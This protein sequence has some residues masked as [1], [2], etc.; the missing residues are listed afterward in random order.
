[1][2]SDNVG[3]FSSI[4]YFIVDGDIEVPILP[5]SEK[6]VHNERI[7]P[8]TDLRFDIDIDLYNSI[9]TKIK[10]NGMTINSSLDSVIDQYDAV[11]SISYHQ[12][13]NV[14]NYTPINDTIRIKAIIR[15]YG[16]TLDT[17]PYIETI[18]IRK[19]GGNTLWTQLY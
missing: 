4:E 2:F 19:Y 7:F 16:S 12:A 18:N 13:D 5:M 1:M 17:I 10:R 6:Y 14:Y 3:E 11:Y 15:Y 9:D 8:E